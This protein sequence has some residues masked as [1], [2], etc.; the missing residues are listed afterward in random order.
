MG[1]KKDG[2]GGSGEERGEKKVR[3]VSW[4]STVSAPLLS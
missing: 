4:K 2:I 1:L 3:M